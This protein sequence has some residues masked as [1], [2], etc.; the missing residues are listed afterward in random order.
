[1]KNGKTTMDNLMK[2]VFGVLRSYRGNP[3]YEDLVS[4]GYLAL[5]EAGETKDQDK[6][7]IVTKA[8][9]H[10]LKFVANPVYV[11]YENKYDRRLSKKTRELGK[12]SSVVVDEG[13][14]Y[15][16]DHS[17]KVLLLA[18]IEKME[19]DARRLTLLKTFGA[20]RGTIMEK[21]GISKSY[22]YTLL[23]KIK[24]DLE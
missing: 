24:E 10:Y 2:A 15:V 19:G 12:V 14:N 11:P 23:E 1:M 17:D 21:L 5:L 16:S 6:P 18:S 8:V 13:D 3:H 20:T 7:L 22:Y 9:N 4:E